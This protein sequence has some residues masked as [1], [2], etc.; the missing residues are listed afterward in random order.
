MELWPGY[1]TSIRQ[2]EEWILMCSDIATKFMRIDTVLYLLNECFQEE[3][4]QYQ[5]NFK[6]K[7]IGTVVLTGYN[8]KT[9][10]V[11]DVDWDSTPES[12]FK[13]NDGTSISYQ[14]YFK[15]VMLLF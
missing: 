13:R 11:D 4:S 5:R 6:S 10:R 14:Q 8:N 9:Y 15:E 2:H 12:T 7:I 3:R 1:I